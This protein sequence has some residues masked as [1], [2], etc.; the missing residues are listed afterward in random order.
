M[1]MKMTVMQMKQ[2]DEQTAGVMEGDDYD[3]DEDD[4][5]SMDKLLV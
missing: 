5:G 1:V 2:V 4:T 3:S